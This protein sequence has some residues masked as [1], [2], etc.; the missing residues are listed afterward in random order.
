MTAG[1]PA[2][3]DV[4]SFPIER[5]GGFGACQLVA[6]DDAHQSATVAL[7]DWTGER[8]PELTDLAGVGRMGKD[9]MFWTPREILLHVPLPAPAQY[10]RL[11]TLPVTG[12]TESRSYS[13]WDF[14]RD[15]SRQR[16]WDGL[17]REL[18][19]A[20][21]ATLARDDEAERVTVP[22]LLDPA[23]GEPY[24]FRVRGA[25]RLADDARYRIADDFRLENL[26]SW[27]L[28]H[29]I[30][31]HSW[32]DDLIGFLAT[33]P[34]VSEL[35]LAGHGQSTLDFSDT[36]L[37]QLSV[38]LAGLSRLVLPASLDLLI[39]LG[40]ADRPLRV[41]AE[42]GGRWL[43]VH[44]REE[45]PVVEGL[46]S[47][48]GVRVD[49]I[50]QLDVAELATRFPQTGY[51]LLFGAPGLL[52]GLPSL[53]DFPRLDSIWLSDL[54]GY[55][56]G[57]LPGPDEL[58]A[59]TS[60]DLTSI[61]AEVATAARTA[62]GKHPRV[63]LTV[64]RP[65]KANWLAENLENPL[66]HWDGR[67]GIPA[68]VAKRARTAFVTALRQVREADAVRENPAAYDQSVTAAVIP[69]LDAIAAA[70]RRHGFLYTLE[71]DEV[72]D[73]VGVLTQHLSAAA[74]LALEPVVEEALDD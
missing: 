33:A 35:V 5:L 44:L 13:G 30:S 50:R 67:E 62:Y 2:P 45:V 64:S 51:L 55:G 6:V 18:T 32:R 1:Q 11:G 53:R 42:A 68:S 17:P 40:R 54:F 46:E 20:F 70:N 57:D 29:K 27:P 36:G 41:E 59:L 26:R 60:L 12:E 15:I 66:R 31:L 52:T 47:T 14:T 16:W 63:Q 28:L 34:L 39:L 23:T 72:V 25:D 37:T 61:P 4:Y 58:P 74:K 3:G 22:G 24:R 10:R 65:R 71:R 9:F 21:K 56:P 69:F 19:A 8:E 73:A 49:G 43:T 48:H 38:D 7:L